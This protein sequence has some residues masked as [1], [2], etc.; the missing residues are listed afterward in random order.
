MATIIILLS[1]EIFAQLSKSSVRNATCLATNMQ[2]SNA[3]YSFLKIFNQIANW[4]RDIHSLHMHDVD[5]NVILVHKPRC[6]RLSSNTH[7]AGWTR[8][9]ATSK[10]PN[11]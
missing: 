8:N 5:L 7:D 2:I 9:V 11:K 6:G 10:R 3:T 1:A 4:Y